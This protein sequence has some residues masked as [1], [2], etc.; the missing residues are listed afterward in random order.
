[1]SQSRSKPTSQTDP[2]DPPPQEDPIHDVP[3]YPEQDPP[4]GSEMPIKAADGR[5]EDD[6]HD[7]D[8]D[9]LDPQ[10]PHSP[11]DAGKPGVVF[12]ENGVP[13]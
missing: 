11:P 2:N 3:V 9:D 8:E 6:H 13:G 4:P 5:S 12:D 7:V 10:T 1:M